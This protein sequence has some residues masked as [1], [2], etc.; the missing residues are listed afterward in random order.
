MTRWL[1]LGPGLTKED[2]LWKT[3][4]L[5]GIPRRRL[6]EDD[7]EE[8]PRLCFEDMAPQS[9]EDLRS[10]NLSYLRDQQYKNVMPFIAAG[11]NVWYISY[12]EPS[13]KREFLR[14]LLR[15]LAISRENRTIAKRTRQKLPLC[16]S[17][18]PR[19]R[20]SWDS[21]DIG[22]LEIYM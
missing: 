11:L 16:D 19:N 21:F 18:S 5:G 17:S 2:P 22:H 1:N 7:L 15:R 20:L 12:K 6:D 4:V 3:H 10:R 9:F 13:K 8:S 14:S